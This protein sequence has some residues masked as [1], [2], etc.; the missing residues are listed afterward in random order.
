MTPYE[1]V[2]CRL[3]GKEVD[4]IPNMNIAMALV[5]KEA[6]TDYRTY[7]LDYRK[8]VEGNLRCVEKY[9]FDSVSVIS[10]PVR[11]AAAFGSNLIFPQDGVPY[12]S[13]PLLKNG[14]DTDKLKIVSPYDNDRTLDHIRAVEEFRIRVGGEIP[15]IGWVEGVLAE[16]ADLRGVSELLMD[17]A[18]EEDLT[19]VM[20]IIFRQ[21]CRFMEAQVKA[22]ADII[23]IGNA[24]ASLVGPSLYEEYAFKYD[25]A[26]IDYL[27]Q[28]GAKAK[29]HICGNIT[30][31]LSQLKLL[32]ADILDF[33]W[34]VECRDIRDITEGTSV[35]I[36][37]NI[38]P[39]A[40]MLQGIEKDVA[41]K[42]GTCIQEGGKRYIAACGCEVSKDSPEN[43]LKAM[44]DV[45][46]IK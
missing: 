33:D 34:M 4:K 18:E 6:G 36:C 28:M 41:E 26:T 12:C 22:G 2:K 38:D 23:G 10:D 17:L 37:G 20:D 21:Q 8:L 35:C 16:C 29:L 32:E 39:V 45:L 44:D 5:A 1:R 25:K 31:L 24:V 30:P 13:E 27:H 3:E 15:I 19:E 7:V 11:E 46:Y 40:V 9:G 14:Y 43:N 42:T